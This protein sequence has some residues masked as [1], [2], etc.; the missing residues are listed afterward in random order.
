MNVIRIAVPYE[1]IQRRRELHAAFARLENDR[2]LA[3]IFADSPFYC[4]LAGIPIERMYQSP[5]DMIA[6]QVLGWKAV[7]EQVDC[8]VPGVTVNLD[9]GCCL[10]A[11]AYGCELAEQPGSVPGIHAWF[12]SAADLERLES[13]DVNATGLR[14]TELDYYRRFQSLA[15]QFAVQYDGGPVEYPARSARLSTASDGPFSI[16]CMIAGF[17][18]VCAWCYD[19]R[20]LLERMMEIIVRKEIERIRRSYREMNLPPGPIGLADDYSPYVSLDMYRDLI[21][22]RQQAL[23]DAFGKHLFFHSCIPDAKLLADWRDALA[24][25][26][27]NGFK[28]LHG[29]GNLRRDYTP[30]AQAM[31]GRIPLEPDLDGGN[32]MLVSEPGL[33]AAVTE[34]LDVF[35]GCRGL[36][37]GATLCGGHRTDDLAK[38]NAIKRTILA[39]TS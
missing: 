22:P 10:L 13:L 8:D 18:R 11:S 30:V 35:A 34:C 3:H 9:F 29:L 17:D 6:A 14:P 19:D 27:F 32:I 15:E 25:R 4:R 28:P 37:I 21:L 12:Q 16:A 1:E 38:M 20:P 7:L 26:L 31:G 24:I 2:P 39:A 5:Q 23:R 36:K 33:S